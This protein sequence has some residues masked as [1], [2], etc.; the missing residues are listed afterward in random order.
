MTTRVVNLRKEPFD[1]YIGRAG[2]GQDGYFGNPYRVSTYG[3][4]GAILMFSTYFYGRIANE[5]EFRRR[6]E[7]LR[8][9]TLGCFC[10]PAA[11][12][13]GKLICHG[14]IIAGWCDGVQPDCIT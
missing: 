2:H 3:V 7:E 1:V 6:V 10:R 13:L 12:F 14:Q 4:E 9:R 8:G 11:G 5:P